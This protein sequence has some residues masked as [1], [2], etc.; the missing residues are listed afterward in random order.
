MNPNR[1]NGSWLEGNCPHRVQPC[2]N[3]ECADEVMRAVQN[4]SQ[5]IARQ[6][7]KN[8]TRRAENC[9]AEG[10][11]CPLTNYTGVSQPT[12]AVITFKQIFE[13]I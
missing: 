4:N 11:D 2:G 9:E 1:H 13:N 7:M 6:A 3:A 8:A 12:E 5:H 10:A